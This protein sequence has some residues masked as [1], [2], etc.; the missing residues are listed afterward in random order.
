MNKCFKKNV[1]N[2][3]LSIATII[4]D[5][6]KISGEC[7]WC[8]QFKKNSLDWALLVQGDTTMYICILF[9]ELDTNKCVF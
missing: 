3:L 8:L 9:L 7:D 2:H 5:K 4:N 6:H 1:E